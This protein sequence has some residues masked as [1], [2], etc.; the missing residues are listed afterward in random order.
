[1]QF[2]K[3]RSREPVSLSRVQQLADTAQWWA[4]E[5]ELRNEANVLR[6]DERSARIQREAYAHQMR[7]PRDTW[8]PE[9]DG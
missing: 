2:D 4:Q 6:E 9:S 8:D 7:Q 1:M 3:P 5:D